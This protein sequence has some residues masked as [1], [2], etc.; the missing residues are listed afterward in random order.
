MSSRSIGI[1]RQNH[2]EGVGVGDRPSAPKPL[3]LDEVIETLTA[4]RD[5]TELLG[6][7]EQADRAALYRALRLTV[8]YRRI[9]S[10][11]EVKL[12][13]TL[14]GVD[15]E[16]VAENSDA[17]NFQITGLRGVDLERVGG[18]TGNLGPRP[19]ILDSGW[20]ELRQV[21]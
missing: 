3:S 16:Y 18:P 13:S 9:G 17:R 8:R 12:T 21:A 11:E 5:L 20:S 15:L 4:L 1:N 2:L 6:R 19:V 14:R 10:T 7:I